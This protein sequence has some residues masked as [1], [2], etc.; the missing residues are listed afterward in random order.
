MLFTHICQLFFHFLECKRLRNLLRLLSFSLTLSTS[1]VIADPWYKEPNPE[2]KPPPIS[3][4][5]LALTSANAIIDALGAKGAEAGN[6]ILLDIPDIFYTSKHIPVRIRSE[7]NDTELIV[8]IIDRLPRPIFL[9][10]ST[11]KTPEPDISFTIDLERT[12]QTRALIKAGGKWY[13]VE[14]TLRLATETWK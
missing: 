13:S 9:A 11:Q 8:F 12:S 10:I 5:I 6:K 7:L 14:K 1:Y 3:E 2:R 4:K